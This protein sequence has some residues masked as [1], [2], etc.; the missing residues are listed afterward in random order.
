M[1][2]SLSCRCWLSGYQY[3]LYLTLLTYSY[4]LNVRTIHTMYRTYLLL[5]TPTIDGREEVRQRR[6]GVE[7]RVEQVR[8][9][10]YKAALFPREANYN[11]LLGTFPFLE[12][13]PSRD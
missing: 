4:L 10:V 8:F 1:N 9:V 5:L 13:T 3:I 7:L 12:S 11:I 6:S 2:L